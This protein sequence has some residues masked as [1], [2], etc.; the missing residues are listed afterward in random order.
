MHKL[1]S[2]SCSI[3]LAWADYKYVLPSWNCYFT[4]SGSSPLWTESRLHYFGR[5]CLS[6]RNTYFAGQEH[7]FQSNFYSIHVHK[8]Q[9]TRTKGLAAYCCCSHTKC[10]VFWNQIK[11]CGSEGV[12][13][14]FGALDPGGGFGH[15]LFCS[16][17]PAGSCTNVQTLTVVAGEL[18]SA[19]TK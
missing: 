17:Q 16:S 19:D 11:T 12:C 3:F 9:N 6:L 18:A 15:L 13:A 10:Q 4:S 5:D 7:K 2:C 14:C 8:C 1:K